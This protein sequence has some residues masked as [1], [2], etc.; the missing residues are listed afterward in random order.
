LCLESM[1]GLAVAMG[2]FERAARLAGVADMLRAANAT[3][4]EA[5]DQQLYD[6]ITSHCREAL[7]EVAHAAAL[8]AGRA[9][10]PDEAVAAAL[11]WLAGEVT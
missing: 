6:E 9:Q 1:M 11:M 5:G 8:A 3:P 2:G 7:G 4:R 10:S